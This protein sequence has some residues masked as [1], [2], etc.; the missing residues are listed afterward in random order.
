MSISDCSLRKMRSEYAHR[1]KLDNDFR[2]DC[3]K[4]KFYFDFLCPGFN[5]KSI[6]GFVHDIHSNPFGAILVSEIQV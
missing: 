2:L 4:A 5:K 1:F 6:E 3:D